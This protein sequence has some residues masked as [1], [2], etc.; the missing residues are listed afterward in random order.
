MKRKHGKRKEF[1]ILHEMK[2]REGKLQRKRSIKKGEKRERGR[3]LKEF[4]E[5]ERN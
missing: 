5:K 3:N 4:K 1:K 2:Q